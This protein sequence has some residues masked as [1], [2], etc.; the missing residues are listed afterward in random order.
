MAGMA[1]PRGSPGRV[2][3]ENSY[4]SRARGV[5]SGEMLFKMT[6]SRR[7]H[8]PEDCWRVRCAHSGRSMCAQ[9]VDLM[10]DG[11]SESFLS[12][13]PAGRRDIGYTRHKRKL[14]DLRNAAFQRRRC[15]TFRCWRASFLDRFS[16]RLPMISANAVRYLGRD[17]RVCHTSEPK[18]PLLTQDASA[19]RSEQSPMLML[20]AGR[21]KVRRNLSQSQL[22]LR[23][24]PLPSPP[25]P[26]PPSTHSLPLYLS[27][28]SQSFGKPH[29]LCPQRS[30]LRHIKRRPCLPSLRGRASWQ[31]PSYRPVP[32]TDLDHQRSICPSITPTLHT[33]TSITYLLSY[34][35]SSLPLHSAHQHQH[36]TRH[37][38][39]QS[40]DHIE[41]SR[42]DTSQQQPRITHSVLHYCTYHTI[43]PPETSFIM[44]QQQGQTGPQGPAGR[45]LHIAHRRTPSEM[46]PL[47]SM[48]LTL[49]FVLR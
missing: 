19:Q 32:A 48:F 12:T 29:L 14:A 11:S 16:V 9:L 5:K 13:V 37:I 20:G 28:T 38:G 33:N 46:T 17:R 8:A 22:H 15:L 44:D 7:S 39:Q 23:T 25:R 6:A 35:S 45:R 34:L 27:L 49:L 31:P 2:R 4:R 21:P 30:F 43:Y 41:T 24:S 47:M 42:L 40:S 1:D 10:H 26:R 3:R 18:R 36:S